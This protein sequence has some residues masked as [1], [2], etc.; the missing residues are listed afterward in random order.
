MELS[1]ILESIVCMLKITESCQ[2]KMEMNY[3][4][5]KLGERNVNEM[6]SELMSPKS[7]KGYSMHKSFNV[8]GKTSVIIL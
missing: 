5:L 6:L 8:N 2:E 7:S 4:Y 1:R 3:I